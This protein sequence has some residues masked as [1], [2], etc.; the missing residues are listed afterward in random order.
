VNELRALGARICIDDF[1]TGYS[2]LSYLHTLPIDVLKVDASF[3]RALAG[4]A[5]KIAIIKSILLLGQ[6]LGIEVVAEGV[7]TAE[8][9]RLLEGLG[10]NR[11]QG[12]FF[13][14]PAAIS[15]LKLSN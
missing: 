10:C 5:R 11:A 13:S 12:Y 4:D 1:G 15:A 3:V 7:E 8:Q 14:R 2:S 6:G 9:A